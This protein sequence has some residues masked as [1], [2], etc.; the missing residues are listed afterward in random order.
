VH[1]VTFFGA[2][3]LSSQL[4]LFSISGGMQ[5]L[6]SAL[7]IDEKPSGTLKNRRVYFIVQQAF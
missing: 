4:D 6:F 2:F 5:I 3:L 1:P 7:I